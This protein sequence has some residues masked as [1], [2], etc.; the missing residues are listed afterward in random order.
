MALSA[1]LVGDSFVIF[2]I[3]CHGLFACVDWMF[4]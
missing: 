3:G 2:L 1:I 4:V